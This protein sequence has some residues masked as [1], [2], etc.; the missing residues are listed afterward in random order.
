[1]KELIAPDMV[2]RVMLFLAVAG[3]IV[4]LIVGLF[5]GAHE[6][7]SWPRMI[8][9]ILVGALGTVAYGMWRVYGFITNALGLDSIAN[10]ALQF[11]MFVVLGVILGTASAKISGLLKRLGAKG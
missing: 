7:C 4:G 3:P 11:V 1:M 2:E 9:G 5:L 6:R 8:G 10:L